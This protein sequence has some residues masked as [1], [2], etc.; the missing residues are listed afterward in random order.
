MVAHGG[1]KRVSSFY[2]TQASLQYNF[3]S[4][5]GVLGVRSHR[6]H[7]SVSQGGGGDLTVPKD[8]Q[9]RNRAVHRAVEER[10]DAH[11]LPTR[12]CLKRSAQKSEV[13][14]SA[15]KDLLE[16]LLHDR[17]LLNRF[18]TKIAPTGSPKERAGQEAPQSSQNS[19]LFTKA[20]K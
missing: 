4:N 16:T 13:Y 7:P 17:F 9:H 1:A 8:A 15:A 2:W 19:G 10:F 5:S 11:P 14:R 12:S 3:L 18:S 6:L 20:P